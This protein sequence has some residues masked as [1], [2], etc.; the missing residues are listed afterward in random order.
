MQQASEAYGSTLAQGQRL[1]EDRLRFR[2][3]TAS[4]VQSARYKDMAF[5]IFPQ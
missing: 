5:R 4:L 3:Q 1:L 2:Q